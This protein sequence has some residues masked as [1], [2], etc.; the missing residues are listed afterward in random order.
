M[1]DL[2]EISST[3]LTKFYNMLSR[4][5]QQKADNY[6]IS[7]LRNNYIAAR[8]HL[9]RL[10]AVFTDTRPDEI[11]FVYGPFGKPK[12]S[13]QGSPHFN[14][15]HSGDYAVFAFSHA[16]EVGID[17]EVIRGSE[18]FLAL[19]SLCLTEVERKRLAALDC[20]C[21]R[22]EFL[23]A[24]TRKEAYV[25]AIGHGLF[26]SLERIEII[27]TTENCWY[28]RDACSVQEGIDQRWHGV[29]LEVCPSYLAAVAYQPPTS[30][31]HISRVGQ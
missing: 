13:H 4:D 6:Q 26:C 8:G 3:K 9:R 10:L 5:E 14:V 28:S 31:L 18:D 15:S 27:R 17:V 7:K 1:I 12:L 29:D 21:R 30:R 25:K 11:E 16:T 24:W 19:E 22:R 2:S 23:R 20:D